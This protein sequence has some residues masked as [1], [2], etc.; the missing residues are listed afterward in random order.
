VQWGSPL[1]VV[2]AI[3]EH[4]GKVVLARGRGWPEKLYGL[5]TGFLEAGETPAAGCLREVKE[6]LDLDGEVVRLVGVYPF[7][8]RNELIVAFHVRAT[9]TVRLS[10]E[11][12]AYKALEPDRVRSWPFGTGLALQDWLDA[13][14]PAG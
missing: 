6:E 2:A 14:R 11:L 10:E 1:P 13:R 5:V 9:G 12:E 4:E 3:V 7:E 8:P